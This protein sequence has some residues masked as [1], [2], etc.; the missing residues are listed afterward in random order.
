[1]SPRLDNTAEHIR[2][3]EIDVVTYDV[4]RVLL[5]T[6]GSATAI[7]ATEVAVGIAKRFGAELVAIFV[8]PSPAFDPLEESMME[9]S[10]GVHHSRAG[11]RIAELSGAKNG[12]IVRTLVEQGATAHAILDAVVE[13]E[14]DLIVIG[15]TGRTGLKRLMLGSVA[16]AVVREAE[17]PVLVVKH[18]STRYCTAVRTDG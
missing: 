8:D 13:Q 9:A 1:M 6:D 15:N 11:L 14:C 7:E 12:V 16:E 4:K 5:P 18:G 10:E 3:D 17:V 2:D